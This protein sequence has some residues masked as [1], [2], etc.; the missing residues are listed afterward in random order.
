M[1]DLGLLF[2]GYDEE[3]ARTIGQTFSEELKRIIHLFG[4]TGMDETTVQGILDG[5]M[6]GFGDAEPKVMMLLGFEQEQI[7]VVLKHFPP[8]I[9]RPIFCGLT[10]ENLTWTISHLVEHLIEEQKYW[11][12]EARKRKEQN[13]GADVEKAE[14]RDD[15]NNEVDLKEIEEKAEEIETIA[16]GQVEQKKVG[17]KNVVKQE[18]ENEGGDP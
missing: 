11:M 14:P 4:A 13:Q 2:Y 3:T 8:E 7:G 9:P 15:E 6:K 16:E 10:E 1:T 5:S 17:K 18:Q 12:E